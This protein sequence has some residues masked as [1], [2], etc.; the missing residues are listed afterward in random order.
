MQH[1]AIRDSLTNLYN[2]RIGGLGCNHRLC[3]ESD[4]NG[5]TDRVSLGVGNLDG[6]YAGIGF[7]N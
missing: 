6:V 4:E 2:Q 1:M 7:S 3:V 5:F